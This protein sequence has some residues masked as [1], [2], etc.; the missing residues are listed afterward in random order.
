MITSTL[1][2]FSI[3]SIY[4]LKILFKEHL[5]NINNIAFLMESIKNRLEIFNIDFNY[6]SQTIHIKI[7]KS[8]IRK[9]YDFSHTPQFYYGVLNDI[10]IS[11]YLSNINFIKEQFPIKF[12]CEAENLEFFITQYSGLLYDIIPILDNIIIIRL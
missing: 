1:P 8:S 3:D 12:G 5:Y 2:A 7:K 11:F 10:F 6:D 4:K 9:T